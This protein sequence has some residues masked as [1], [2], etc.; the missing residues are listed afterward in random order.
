MVANPRIKI[1]LLILLIVPL[2]AMLQGLQGEY[3][4]YGSAGTHDF[5]AYWSATR[6]ILE[7]GNPYNG[8]ALYEVEKGLGWPEE[9][10][11]LVMNPPWL[12]ILLAPWGLLPFQEAVFLWLLGNILVMALATYFLWQVFAVEANGQFLWA[13][14]AAAFLFPQTLSAIFSGQVSPL[15]LLG[16]SGTLFFIERKRGFWAGAML[17]LTTVKPQLVCLF[18]PAIFLWSVRQKRWEVPIGFSAALLALLFPL[19]LLFP[20]WLPSYVTFIMGSPPLDWFTPTIGGAISYSHGATLPW[21]KLLWVAFLPIVLIPLYRREEIDWPAF[22][23]LLLLL[24]LPTTTFAWGIDQVI[25]VVPLLQVVAWLVSSR[26]CSKARAI[27]VSALFICYATLATQRFILPLLEV[28]QNEVFYLW[29]PFL[30]AAIYLSASLGGGLNRL[31]ER[32]DE[33]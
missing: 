30:V 31:I 3:T 13:A 17:V 1:L 33:G 29:T 4:G 24:T 23:N 11:W 26:L 12:G 5:I 9:R 7:G 20:R 10:P 27:I 8:A 6:L 19:Q 22:T 32:Q 15:V 25:L 2:G 16:I 14:M 28:L 21:A 18:L